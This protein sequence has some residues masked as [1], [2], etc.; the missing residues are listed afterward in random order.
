MNECPMLESGDAS[1][2]VGL[3]VFLTSGGARTNVRISYIAVR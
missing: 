3:L 2:D 1:V